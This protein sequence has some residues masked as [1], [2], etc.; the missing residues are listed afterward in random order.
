MNALDVVRAW[1]AAVS[2]G[3]VDR[4]CALSAPDI[5]VGGPGGTARGHQLVREWIARTGIELQPQRMFR[6]GELVVVEHRA[7]WKLPDGSAGTKTIGTVF[8]VTGSLVA[9][10]TR[11]DSLDQALNASAMTEADAIRELERVDVSRSVFDIH[12]DLSISTRARKPGPPVRI[13]GMTV[14]IETV[15]HDAP[16]AGEV[17]PDGDEILYIGSG[18]MRLQ[19]DSNPDAPLELGP[20]DACIVPK[21]EWHRL[22]VVEPALL[23]H[24]TPG[25][26]GEYRPLK[27]AVGHHERMFRH[28]H[29]H[30]LD[31]PDRE[32]W[33][34]SAA[35]VQQL[36]LRPGMTVA[37]I[38]AGTGYFA[39]PMAHAVAPGGKVFAV[40]MQPEML[41]R[42]RARLQPGLPVVLVEGEATGTTLADHGVDLALY[43]N[44][45]H[46]FDDRAAALSEAARILKPGAR[47][48]ILDWRPDVE[49]PPGPAL[50][51]RIAVADVEATLRT[52]GW[53]SEASRM[54]GSYSDLV[55]ARPERHPARTESIE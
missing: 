30:K 19:C 54:V 24:I 6:R 11:Y 47:I 1:Q 9:G 43:A 20:G 5:E 10:V 7:T 45:W 16:H 14:G 48:A 32:K 51:H 13:D 26:R 34:P 36:G 49:Q 25:P 23:V 44:V 27:T 42:L 39:I 3:D 38:G 50:E 2:G 46:E 33:L 35:I 37:D 12:R 4:A 53:K 55:V 31:D 18:R 52:H 8:R 22:S 41:D 29:A 40:D 28:E 17:H 15:T 21:G